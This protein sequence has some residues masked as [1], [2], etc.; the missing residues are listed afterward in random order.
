MDYDWHK[1]RGYKHFDRAVSPKFLAKVSTPAFVSS[2][3]FS[4]LIHYVKTVRRYKKALRK[5]VI[6]PRDIMYASHRDAAILSFYAGEL[7]GA[8][9]VYYDANGLGDKAIA[10]RALGQS[11]YHFSAQAYRYVQANA[12]CVVLAFDIT[13][14]FDN[15]DHKLL[16]SRLK[17]ILNITDLGDDWRTILKVVTKFHFVTLE[18]IKAHPTLG[19]RLAAKDNAPIATVAELKKHG[20]PIRANKNAQAGIPQGT[21]ISAALSNLYMMDFDRA[22]A[23]ACAKIGA[24]Y[25]RYSDDIMVVCNPADAAAMETE[26]MKLIA[27]EK[28]EIS[29]GKT[30]KTEFDAG[31]NPLGGAAQY[32]GFSYYPGG[33]GLRPG[34]L[35]RQWRKMKRAIKRTAAAA[36]AAAKAGKPSKLYTKKL[37]RRFSSLPF[38]NFSSYARRSAAVFGEGEKITRQ[39]NRLQNR[40]NQELQKLK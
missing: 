22:A 18:D 38:R 1:P 33:A 16:K 35:S 5:T 37:R 39:L 8:L 4:P 29:P 28:L 19:E 11:N 13:G 24:L 12:P 31:A 3:S 36:D 25:L 7:N 27:L 2:H 40:F 15:L 17:K 6:K 26:I 23:E 30:E 34:S 14:F 32:L 10:Y 20:I 9:D 21:P